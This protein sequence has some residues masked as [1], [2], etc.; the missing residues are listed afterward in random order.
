MFEVL[1]KLDEDVTPDF[2]DEDG[3]PDFA[4]EDG[5]P[6]LVDEDVTPNVI[7]ELPTTCSDSIAQLLC[8]CSVI[9]LDMSGHQVEER[10][11]YHLSHSLV[12]N[13]SLVKLTLSYT[14]LEITDSSGPALTEML[15]V[16]KTLQALDMTHNSG[17]TDV[18]AFFIAEGLKHNSGLKHIG[19]RYCGI[20]AKEPTSLLMY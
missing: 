12:T 19:L 6:D 7:Q 16:N 4:D 1:A 18:G 13:A 9:S 8:C 11:L 2:A 17:V 15:K 20:T 5:T 3:T 10:Q 14:S